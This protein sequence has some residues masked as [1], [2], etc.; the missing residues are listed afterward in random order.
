MWYQL[1]GSRTLIRHWG[2]GRFDLGCTCAYTGERR[3]VV[4]DTPAYRSRTLKSQTDLHTQGEQRESNTH[5]G[6]TP[7][8]GVWFVECEALSL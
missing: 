6:H 8:F 7:L 2:V 4:V 5:S 3:S 1:W